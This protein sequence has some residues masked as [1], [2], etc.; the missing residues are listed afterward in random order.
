MKKLTAL[1]LTLTVLIS[2]LPLSALADGRTF[3]ISPDFTFKD[4][5]TTITWTDSANKGPY[6]V[7]YL[8]VSDSEA[9]QTVHLAD[10]YDETGT[11]SKK[12]FVLG[13][14]LPGRTYAVGVFDA[15]QELAETEIT[16]PIPSEFEDG[17]LKAS[18]VRVTTEP[19]RMKRE[20]G[21]IGDIDR[22]EASTIAS[23]IGQ[24]LYGLYYEIKLP[25]LARE[26]D[27]HVQIAL[28][29]PNGYC[30][31]VFCKRNVFSTGTG[32]MS[33]LRMTGATFFYYMLESN[34]SIPVGTY[35]AELYF[36]GMLANV[37]EFKVR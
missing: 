12:S 3:E 28:I 20:N 10:L 24:W 16:L 4:G 33:Y 36:D 37:K 26:R 7:V 11:T 5:L 15:D 13:E 29:A 31:T 32:W 2:L 6:T 34:G 8:L 22:L 18:S 27:Y 21:S 14:L 30:D 25:E 23:T 1:L 17:K 19:R 9:Q 35:S